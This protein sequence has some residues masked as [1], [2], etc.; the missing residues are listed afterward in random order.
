MEI[1]LRAKTVNLSEENMG[2][3]FCNLGFDN[4]AYISHQKHK[5][6]RGKAQESKGKK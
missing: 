1:Y 6:Q 2:L 5:Y 4:C 3:N